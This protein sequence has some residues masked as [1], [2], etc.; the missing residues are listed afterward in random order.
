MLKK[1]LFKKLLPVAVISAVVLSS[2]AGAT[3]D[4]AEAKKGED[5]ARIKNVI[6]LIGDG[7]GPTYTTAY[8][9]FQ[10]DKSTPYSENTAFEEYL[11]GMQETYSWDPDQ[12]VTD[13][14]AAA[15]TMAT[16][17]KTYNGAIAVDMEK[18]NVKTV[19]EQAKEDGKATGLVATSQINHATPASFGAH[20]ESRNNYN[21]IADSYFDE[22]INGQHKIDVMLGG[23]TAYF[24]REDRNLTEEFQQDGYSYVTTKQEMANDTNDQVLGLFAPKAMD[25]MIDRT[26]DAPSLAD[27]TD[28]ALD[29]LSQDKDGFFLM[30]EGSQ[31]DWAGHDNDAVS[32]MSE[33]ADF[34]AAYKEAIE[35]AKKDKHTLVVTTADHSTGGMTMG[36]DGEYK[37]DPAP[38]KAAKRTPDFMAGEIADGANVEETLKNYIDL[39]LT[40]EEI[41]SVKGAA[42]E[43][44][45]GDIDAAIERIFDIRS[46]TGWTTGG[47]T[48][49]DVN[50]YA[51]GPESDKFAGLNDNSETGQKVLE[52]LSNNRKKEK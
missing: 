47:H 50:V 33:M 43:G 17:I 2:L 39:E 44:S 3:F 41:Q 51:Y 48:G 31:I 46:G 24:D 9:S 38:L 19:L 27:M 30:V 5:Q 20:N 42:V 12:S 22:L 49:V 11:V 6:F 14:A 40:Q 8:R 32:A 28:S 7:M 26:E 18:N 35:F 10:D 52:V 13:S 36:R 25:K 34:E 29:R 45:T 4:K 37:W 15:T 16:G 1:T 23:G 21:E